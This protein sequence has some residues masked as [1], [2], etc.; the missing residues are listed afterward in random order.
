MLLAVRAS[1]GAAFPPMLLYHVNFQEEQ[2]VRLYD[3]QG[4]MQ[5]SEVRRL[6]SLLRCHHS[7]KRHR[8][9][10]R[11]MQLLYRVSR[12]YDG[13]RIEIVSGYRDRRYARTR[14][15]AHTEGRAVDFQVAGV[16][17]EVLRDFLRTF[18]NV[19]VGFYPNSSFVHLDVRDH[20]AFWIDYS[21][22]GESA[23]YSEDPQRELQ[24]ERILRA[25]TR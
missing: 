14:H 7:G 2:N 4:R 12:H 20:N 18:P 10:S 17:H 13:R 15:S 8:I 9:D 6:Q 19:G 22:P 5:K 1:V 16:T 3:S 11:L 21:G 23:K 24:I 25:G